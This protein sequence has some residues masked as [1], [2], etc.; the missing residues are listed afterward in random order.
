MNKYVGKFSVVIIDEA[1]QCTEPNSI[2]P[3]RLGV[4]KLVLIGDHK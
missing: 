3:L 4:K 2:I 1:A